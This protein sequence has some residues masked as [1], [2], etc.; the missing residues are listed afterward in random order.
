M[1]LKLRVKPFSFH[2]LQTLQTS[3]GIIREKQGWLIN[4]ENESGDVGWG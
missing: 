2:L 1:Q 4:L 3:Q